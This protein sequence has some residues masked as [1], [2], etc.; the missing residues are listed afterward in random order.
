MT[1]LLQL[2]G[3]QRSHLIAKLDFYLSQAENRLIS[4]FG[5]I[6]GEAEA[7]AEEVYDRLGATLDPERYDSA[8]AADMA[9]DSSIEHYGMLTDMRRDVHLSVAAGMFHE[10]KK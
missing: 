8:D 3:P 5:D 2:W 4:Q 7:H 9:R 6:E 10:W 1:V